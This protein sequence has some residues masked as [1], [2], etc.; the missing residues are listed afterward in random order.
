MNRP[1][2]N[3]HPAWAKQYIDQVSADTGLLDVLENQLTELPELLDTF[4]DKADYAY[5][6]GKW[7]VK[8]M[9]GHIIDTERILCYRLTAFSR[10]ELAELPG[11]EEEDYVKNARFHERS[12]TDLTEEF[13]LLRKGN[14]Y[15]FRSLNETDLNR[16]GVASGRQIS[17]RSILYVIAGHVNHHSRILKERYT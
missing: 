12:L 6:P 14:Q 5:A 8:E 3:E 4:Q 15:L 17:V 7:T 9:L 2:P 11:F 13:I 10:G 1:Q 16:S